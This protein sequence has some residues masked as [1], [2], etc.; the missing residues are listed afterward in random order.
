MTPC[1]DHEAELSALLDGE[2]DRHALLPTLDHLVDCPSCR[3]FYRQARALEGTLAEVRTGAGGS[4]PPEVWHRIRTR[5]QPPWWRQPLAWAAAAAIALAAVALWRTLPGRTTAPAAL[6]EIRLGQ[7]SGSMTD[8]RFVA[9]TV[10]ILRSD[11]RYR[12][13][14]AQVLAEVERHSTAREGSADRPGPTTEAQAPPR[15]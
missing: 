11:W 2:L 10:E 3:R 9:L 1:D 6:E 7:E 13:T 4:A 8:E 5:T 15:V 12:D 14:L